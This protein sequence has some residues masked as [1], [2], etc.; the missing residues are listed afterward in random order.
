MT[1]APAQIALCVRRGATNTIPIRLAR[2]E[3][4][5]VAITAITAS[6]PVR[7]TAP[8]HAIP[9]RWRALI[10]GVRG[11][12][13]I[14]TARPP[15][16]AREADWQAVTVIDA[17]TLEINAINAADFAAYAGGGHVQIYTP[18]DLSA[19]ASARMQINSA[20]G[21]LLAYYTT[22]DA[23]RIDAASAT[24]TLTLTPD[25]SRLIA[26]SGMFDVEL[27]TADGAVIN[28][29]APTSTLTVIDEQTK[30][31]D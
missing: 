14:N 23:L 31:H 17:D 21:A 2:S 28:P 16:K 8:G 9:D 18:M 24:L 25:Q 5:Y 20:D 10:Y 7:I 13:A 27:V 4:R 3:W 26:K 29:V 19:I 12:T 15:D 30:N 1:C 22:D 11:M 6:A